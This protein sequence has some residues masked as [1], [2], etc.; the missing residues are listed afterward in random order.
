MAVNV[1]DKSHKT[2]SCLSIL[3][4]K[5]REDEMDPDHWYWCNYHYSWVYGEDVLWLTEEEAEALENQWYIENEE[6]DE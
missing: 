5:F 4:K 3:E 2:S 1:I 6:E